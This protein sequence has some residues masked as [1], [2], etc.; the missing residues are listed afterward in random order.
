MLSEHRDFCR[1]AASGIR[2]RTEWTS[3][4]GAGRGWIGT[5]LGAFGGYKRLRVWAASYMAAFGLEKYLQVQGRGRRAGKRIN[6]PAATQR[7]AS[8]RGLS[9]RELRP[10]AFFAAYPQGRAVRGLVNHDFF[11]KSI[12]RRVETGDGQAD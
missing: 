12:A 2:H 8:H 1:S 4:P 9:R 11:S 7:R 6:E 3:N 5:G 10:P